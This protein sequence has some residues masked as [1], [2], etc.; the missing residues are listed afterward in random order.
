MGLLVTLNVIMYGVGGCSVSENPLHS[1]YYIDRTMNY[2]NLIRRLPDLFNV[3]NRGAW[4]R[5]KIC[6]N[7]SR[8]LHKIT[9]QAESVIL[10]VMFCTF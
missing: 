2:G 1:E 6:E 4:G 10:T 9:I 5:D 7:S 8:T 3:K